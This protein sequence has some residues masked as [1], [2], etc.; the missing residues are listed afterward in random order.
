[1][2]RSSKVVH[3]LEVQFRD[4]H[5]N[6]AE[7]VW[8]S[9]QVASEQQWDGGKRVVSC[10]QCLL[11][12]VN[13]KFRRTQCT[14]LYLPFHSLQAPALFTRTHKALHNVCCPGRVG[15]TRRF[16]ISAAFRSGSF[17]GINLKLRL[18]SGTAQCLRW[19]ASG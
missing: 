13:F 2:N 8:K 15:A 11:R 7:Q 14:N 5:G 19:T 1:L 17:E 16:N 3:I 6:R 10:S 18:H 4:T 9:K 12:A